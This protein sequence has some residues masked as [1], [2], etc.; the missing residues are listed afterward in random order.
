ML[1]VAAQLTKQAVGT[2]RGAY[3]LGNN[4]AEGNAPLTAQ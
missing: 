1:Q 2:R 3:V 4:W